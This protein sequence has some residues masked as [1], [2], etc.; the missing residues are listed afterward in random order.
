VARSNAQRQREEGRTLHK[1]AAV[2]HAIFDEEAE[3]KRRR[4]TGTLPLRD[5]RTTEE[6]KERRGFLR[7]MRETEWGE[8]TIDFD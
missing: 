6:D 8:L 2:W 3:R 1:R 7:K 4:P 5:H